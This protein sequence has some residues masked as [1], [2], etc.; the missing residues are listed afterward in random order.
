V[1]LG[2]ALRKMTDNKPWQPQDTLSDK[3][4]VSRILLEQY[5]LHEAKH[6]LRVAS[7]E[8]ESEPV[9]PK[10]HTVSDVYKCLHQGE[11]GIGHSIQDPARFGEVLLRELQLA[12]PNSEEPILENV[13]CAGS[14]FR[15]NLRPY[16][17]RFLGDENRASALLLGVCL[18]SAEVHRGEGGRFPA[19]LEE[20]RDLNRTGSFRVEETVYAFSDALVDLFLREVRDFLVR[21]GNIPVLSHS[22][23]YRRYNAPSYRVVDRFA[24]ASSR[25][26]SILDEA[27]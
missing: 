10:A 5:T 17:R 8:T 25:L 13:S 19:I 7:S 24:L 21:W 26:S 1:N 4:G 9:V 14:V 20:F 27:T 18:E 23:A 12:E 15:L 2:S 22:E 16:R 11:F 6:H 3:T